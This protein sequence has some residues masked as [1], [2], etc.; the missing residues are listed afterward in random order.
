MIA[1]PAYTTKVLLVTAPKAC[2]SV[3]DIASAAAACHAHHVCPEVVSVRVPL[4][5]AAVPSLGHVKAR[6]TDSMQAAS[7]QQA[8]EPQA[9][10]V[11]HVLA[12]Q[13]KLLQD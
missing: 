13:V 9:T 2:E 8:G 4:A 10:Q 7:K 6:L 3:Q 11:Q 12:W 5:A 1:W